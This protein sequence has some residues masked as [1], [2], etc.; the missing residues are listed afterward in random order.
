M[1]VYIIAK[2][3]YP[4]GMAT[5]RRVYN[6]AKGI[7][8][9]NVP[10][11]I[12]IP[13]SLERYGI[14]PLNTQSEGVYNGT[15]FRYM[16]GF[17]QRR[18]NIFVRQFDDFMGYF[19]TLYYIKRNAK[20]GDVVFV[21]GTGKIW[22]WLLQYVTHLVNAKSVM[23]LCELPYGTGSE[24]ASII[25]NRKLILKY[26]FPKYDGFITISQSLF[27][28]AKQYG[29][30][31][32]KILKVPI[33][34]NNENI[35]FH[36]TN[37]NRGM[38]IFHSGTLYEQKD[39]ILGMLQAFAIASKKIN[40]PLKF[41]LTGNISDSPY[42]DEIKRIIDINR[43]ETKVVFTGYLSQEKLIDYQRNCFLTIINKYDNQQNRYCFSTKLGEYLFFSRP[44][45]ITNVGEAMYYLKNN[46]NAY[47]VEPSNPELIADKIIHAYKNPEERNRIAKAGQELAE[48]EFNY[49][50]HGKRLVSFF[51]YL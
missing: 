32:T 11:E 31:Q 35:T 28:L 6:Y 4:M 42:K 36:D 10:C 30:K 19:K 23:E 43:L 41:Y 50:Y 44:V 47:I 29:N 17:P 39:G 51:R 34:I 16:S 15:Y 25:R 3:S 20:K 14:K 49:Y 46:I 24:N 1:K 22:A 8:K 37:E 21:Y 27:E 18:S 38:Y 48:T 12:L 2:A 5:T 7:V 45:I 13:I 26:I 9:N 33:L 40:V